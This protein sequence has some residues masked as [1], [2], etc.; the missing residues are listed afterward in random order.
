MAYNSVAGQNDKIQQVK[1]DR[2][3]TFFDGHCPLTGFYFELLQ[4]MFFRKRNV[5]TI[6][7]CE[8]YCSATILRRDIWLDVRDYH[9]CAQAL[10]VVLWLARPLRGSCGLIW[11]I[12]WWGV[13]QN[14]CRFPER[15]S[16][17]GADSINNLV[18]R[19]FLRTAR[20]EGK[21]LVSASHV[22][23]R[24]WMIN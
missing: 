12:S 18:P 5:H 14:P 10:C 4:T 17:F 23:P 2:A 15:I 8:M 21:T 6:N 3:K 19:V 1:S 22:S 20:G 7:L 13:R 24:F 11:S 16:I 9:P